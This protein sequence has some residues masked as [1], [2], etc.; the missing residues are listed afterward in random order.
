MYRDRLYRG[1]LGRP[2]RGAAEAPRIDSLR[3]AQGWNT[4]LRL[5]DG[6]GVGGRLARIDCA[7]DTTLVLVVERRGGTFADRALLDSAGALC[8]LVI[9]HAAHHRS[10]CS[11]P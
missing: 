6:R 1:Q 3:E 8:R 2:H 9:P 7:D 4:A 10:D 11:S 5:A